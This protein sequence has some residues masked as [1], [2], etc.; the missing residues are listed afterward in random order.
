MQAIGYVFG[1]LA[2]VTLFT[3]LYNWLTFE[4]KSWNMKD[5]SESFWGDFLIALM[6]GLPVLSWGVA[7]TTEIHSNYPSLWEKK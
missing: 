6:I 3:A 2:F 4:P 5:Y 7:I 1:V